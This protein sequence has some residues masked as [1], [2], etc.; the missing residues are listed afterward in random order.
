M[1]P[2]FRRPGLRGWT[3]RVTRSEDAP[4]RCRRRDAACFVAAVGCAPL[5]TRG[6]APRETG[7]STLRMTRRRFGVALAATAATGIAP[8]TAAQTWPG[9][10]IRVIVPY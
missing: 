1:P 8:R 4:R 3:I 10:P 5:V 7:M 2:V 9:K 6:V